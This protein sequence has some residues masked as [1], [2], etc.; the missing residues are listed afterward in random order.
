MFRYLILSTVI[1]VGAAVAATAWVNRDLIRIKITGAH[2]RASAQGGAANA[3]PRRTP[4]ALR[5]DAPWALSALPE[6]L[7]QTSE[8]FGSPTY[9]RARLPR[10]AVRV[11][12][13]ATLVYGDCTITI[14][15]EQ[16]YV[17][18]ASD[19]LRIPPPVEFYR[20]PRLLALVRETPKG[21]QLRVYEPAQR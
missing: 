5:G 8:S 10:D 19:R 6:C 11:V 13:P 4:A 7:T 16:A 20:A 15:G 21:A 14:A 12:P 17:Q 9:V 1:V 18:R 2:V 3:W